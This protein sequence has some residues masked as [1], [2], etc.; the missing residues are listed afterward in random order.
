MRPAPPDPPEITHRL[1]K[2][3]SG[4][5]GWDIGANCG[6][7]LGQ[8]I[9]RFAQVYAIEPAE[10][11]RPYLEKWATRGD[12]MYFDVACSDQD[13]TVWLAAV[14]DKIDTGQLVTAGHTGMEWSTESP[15]TVLRS[16]TC[17]SVDSLTFQIPPPDF[18]KIDVEGHELY[19]LTGAWQ[20]IT[21][22]L[23]DMLIE[24]HSADLRE[25]VIECLQV[26]GYKTIETVRHPH[27]AP[28]SAL[29]KGHG[30]IRAFSHR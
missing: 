10:E 22:Y 18:M 16:V 4:A 7:T 8:M 3:F 5:V 24:F 1:W 27:Y 12:V 15:D 9:D 29:W 30:W 28:E 11:C 2:G 19:V 23:P 25:A 13:G 17:R 6:Q 26:H 14:P 20:T 21:D